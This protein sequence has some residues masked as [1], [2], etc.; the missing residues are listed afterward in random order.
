MS[1]YLTLKGLRN[2]G[3]DAEIIQF[4][5]QEGGRLRG[6]DVPVHFSPAPIIPKIDY[7]PQLRKDIRALGKYPNNTYILN[8]C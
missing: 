6:D 5:L 7:A 8:I 4:P 2:K 3:V 1:T